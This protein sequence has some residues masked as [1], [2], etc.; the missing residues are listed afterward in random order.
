MSSLYFERA[1]NRF[2]VSKTNGS[3]DS[4]QIGLLIEFLIS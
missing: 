2:E 3:S 4:K 1:W